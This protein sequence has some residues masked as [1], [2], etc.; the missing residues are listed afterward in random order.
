[1]GPP[2]ATGSALPS[3]PAGR[4]AGEGAPRRTWSVFGDDFATEPASPLPNPPPFGEREW[5]GAFPGAGANH[6]SFVTG[7]ALPSLPAGGRA[8]E[9]V[10]CRTK[11]VS[12]DDFATEPAS[13]LP[14]P[15][16]FGEREWGGAFPGAGGNRPSLATGSALPS[17]PAGGRAGEGGLGRT[18]SVSGDDFATE[19]ASPLPDPPPFGERE[20]GGAFAGAG[21][22]RPSF[23]TGSVL[24]SLPAGG[25]AGEGDLGLT[26]SVFGDDFSAETTS[27]LPN[28][29][30]F[31]ER[32]WG[33]AFPGAGGNHPSLVTG[34]VLP[35]LP[36][37]GR[38]GEEVLCWAW[39][40]LGDDFS[41][42]TTSPLPDPPPFGEREW[43]GAVS[44]QTEAR[45]CA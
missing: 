32:E 38:A 22:N 45:S 30:P 9:G 5:G 26:W 1:M 12:G 43:G 13:P 31:G 16:P 23:V 39:S 36:T 21:A 42:E 6:P 14:N 44:R 8:G 17:L 37:E 20:W 10:L 25:R 4:R 33:G 35:S 11:S 15:P 41:A 24:P 29:P 18:W 40:V 27:P 3:L 2:L 19:P 28:P 34:S 7:S